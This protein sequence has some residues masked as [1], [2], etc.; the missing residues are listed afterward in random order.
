MQR[1]SRLE[2]LDIS[3]DEL[4]KIGEALKEKE[5]RNLFAEYIEEIT[6]PA[7]KKLYEEEIT[8]FEKDRGV[9]VKFVHPKPGYCIKTCIAGE[10][11]AFINICHNDLVKVP[12][13]QIGEENNKPGTSWSIPYSLS[14]PREDYDKKYKRIM[15]YDVVFHPSALTYAC[16]N[17]KFKELLNETACD[18][19][20]KQFKVQLD[21]KNL[22]F[23]KTN[24]KGM[25]MPSIIRKKIPG[26]KPNKEDMEFY[27]KLRP[28]DDRPPPKMKPE[29]PCVKLSKPDDSEYTI[30]KYCIKHRHGID[31]QEYTENMNARLLATVPSQ[32]VIEILLPLLKTSNAMDLDVT[33]KTVALICEKPSK[34][35]L[36]LTLPYPVRED[37]GNAKFEK[38]THKLII[39]LPV[40][41]EAYEAPLPIHQN[42]ELV[43]LPE[44]SDSGVDSSPESQENE[45]LSSTDSG[46]NDKIVVLSESENSEITDA[47]CVPT[48]SE[49][50]T[51]FHKDVIYEKPNFVPHRC[52]NCLI[53]ILTI[54]NVVSDSLVTDKSDNMFNFKCASIGSGYFTVNYGFCL[55]ICC[56]IFSFETDIWCNSVKVELQLEEGQIPEVFEIGNDENHL[57]IC[58]MPEDEENSDSNSGSDDSDVDKNAT[59]IDNYLTGNSI[60]NICE[61]NSDSNSES[62]ES[63]NASSRVEDKDPQ[64]KCRIDEIAND[65]NVISDVP[66]SKGILKSLSKDDDISAINTIDQQYETD[67]QQ[68][69]KSVK[70]QDKVKENIFRKNSSI[71]GQKRKNQRRK[72]NKQRAREI[73]IIKENEHKE[74]S[75]FI[76]ENEQL[77]GLPICEDDP[78]KDNKE[79]LIDFQSD[80]I[81]KLDM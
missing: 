52:N 10:K 22:K 2:D 74:V 56:K 76:Q 71:V 75:G 21:R 64:E 42:V 6:D 29:S 5:F 81:L 14:E 45:N 80:L 34:Y 36:N 38:D 16:Q 67:D 23:I 62:E 39:T 55:K 48:S 54:R 46:D 20:E 26:A 18:G 60:L 57:E 13:Y 35:K 3:R 63:A 79:E 47:E 24:Y 66:K 53:I 77:K 9:D 25:E 69:K 68:D 30:P 27:E 40:K 12:Q 78:K 1:S 33:E 32:I 72:R 65:A 17:P 28:K 49:F 59:V 44:H 19:V 7:N 61:N 70:F 37:E 51:F 4:D 58:K 31:L 41:K 8:Q 43:E 15:I 50:L 11:K 73:K